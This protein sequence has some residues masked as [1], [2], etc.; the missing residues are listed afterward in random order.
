V[1]GLP[2]GLPGLP[3]LLPIV[4][5]VLALKAGQRANPLL[6]E[7]YRDTYPDALIRDVLTKGALLVIGFVVTLAVLWLAA[8]FF[9]AIGLGLVA[10][11]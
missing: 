1:D 7:R 4:L 2:T 5:L 11:R 3:P 8:G 10:R 6:I 9:I